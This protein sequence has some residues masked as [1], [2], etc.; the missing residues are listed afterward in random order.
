MARLN[1]RRLFLALLL[2][3]V[4]LLAFALRLFRL[5]DA[6]IWWD[7][8]LAAWASRMPLAQM[9]AWTGADVHPPL[10]FALLHFWR[11]AAGESEFSLRFLSA[12]FGVLTV[13]ALWRL[14]LAVDSRRPWLALAGAT[15]LALSRFAIWWS[16]DARMYM[17]GGL[18]CTLSLLLTLLLR[19]RFT[20]RRALAWLLVTA[21]ALWTLYLLAFL[22][23]IEGLY[24]LFSLRSQPN[25]RQRWRLLWR[26]AVLQAGVLALFLPWLL[27]ALPRLRSW[28]VQT[29]FDAGLFARLYA[30]LLAVGVSTDIDAWRWPTRL[31]ITLLLLG[32]LT[33][34][35]PNSLSPCPLSPPSLLPPPPSLVSPRPLP[36]L[37]LTV[38]LPLR[39]PVALTTPRLWLRPQTR[40]PL[41]PALRPRLLPAGGLGAGRVPPEIRAPGALAGPGP[42][43]RPGC[44]PNLEPDRLLPRPLSG[45]RL[46]LAR[47]NT[48]R[49]RPAGR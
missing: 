41:P 17:L 42:L 39:S 4:L 12:A 34:L 29:A 22:L 23:I 7:E 28:S 40:S 43:L 19:R 1:P 48:A 10:Y 8:G 24:W 11:L 6:N 49:P 9:A 47:P 21:A 3:A 26:W 15:L 44:R 5:Q 37:P 32:L 45:R 20:A 36:L 46:P 38:L 13:A 25:A 27:Y 30:T 14:G 16:Q 35:W 31:V 18:L 2:P 33:L